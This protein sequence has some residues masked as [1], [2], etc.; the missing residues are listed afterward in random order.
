MDANSA[1]LGVLVVMPAA[2]PLTENPL[3]YRFWLDSHLPLIPFWV[4]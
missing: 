2:I 3:T 1:S 4:R